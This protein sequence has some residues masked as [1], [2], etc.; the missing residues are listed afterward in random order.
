[1]DGTLEGITLNTL[2]AALVDTIKRELTLKGLSP[3]TVKTYLSFFRHCLYAV[4]GKSKLTANPFDEVKMPKVR[5]TKD[6]ILDTPGGA[7]LCDPIGPVYA[8]WVRLAILTGLRRGEQLKLTWQDIDFER[9][10]CAFQKTKTGGVQYVPLND[11]A[12][13]ILRRLCDEQLE[14]GRVSEWVF[15][16]RNLPALYWRQ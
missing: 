8:P 5:A 1:M 13:A 16:L 11:E 12:K 15:L 7:A 14:R 10:L 9:A 3:Q 6:A 4:V 2:T